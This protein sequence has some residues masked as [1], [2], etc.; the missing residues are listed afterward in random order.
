MKR[1][2]VVLIIIIIVAILSLIIFFA[3][4]SRVSKDTFPTVWASNDTG[5]RDLGNIGSVFQGQKYR[6]TI[7]VTNS[8]N[9]PIIITGKASCNCTSLMIEPGEL[10]PGGQAKVSVSVNTDGESSAQDYIKYLS[11]ILSCSGKV[12]DSVVTIPISLS[13]LVKKSV[14]PSLAVN[15]GRK[16][17]TRNGDLLNLSFNNNT[18]KP[19]RVKIDKPVISVF[20]VFIPPEGV[21]IPP[22]GGIK[23][24]VQL[25]S[26]WDGMT[27][28]EEKIEYQIAIDEEQWTGNV[29][30][31]VYPQLLFVSYPNTILV[32]R[33]GNKPERI[34]RNIRIVDR[35]G[36][37]AKDCRIVKYDSDIMKVTNMGNG[38][39]KIAVSNKESVKRNVM[40]ECTDGDNRAVVSIPVIVVP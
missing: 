34:V 21:T 27:D 29:P 8:F 12:Q 33:K 3:H 1:H 23:I 7:L 26:M 13:F 31:R 16:K 11:I 37:P 25:T 39:F 28:V 17:Q 36:N 2:Y 6:Q 9:Y 38:E 15:F 32:G 4:N 30:V 14:Q 40:I 10:E 22:G 35:E 20:K 18:L 5:T 19:A 24:P